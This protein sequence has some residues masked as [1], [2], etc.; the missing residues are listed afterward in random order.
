MLQSIGQS[1]TIAA[2]QTIP[3]T[4]TSTVGDVRQQQ[5]QAGLT[6]D[7]AAQ[8]FQQWLPFLKAQLLTQGAG[9]LPGGSATST[10][11]SNS[12][13]SPLA[14]LIGGTAAAGGAASGLSKLLPFLSAA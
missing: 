13:A 12:D 8:Q 1:P 10:G 14:M 7:T 9:A 4:T 6:A 3:G 11:T 5:T 2:A